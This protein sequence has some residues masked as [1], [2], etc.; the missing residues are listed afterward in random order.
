MIFFAESLRRGED[1]LVKMGPS[2]D[3]LKITPFDD[4]LYL[5]TAR[6]LMK[7]ERLAALKAAYP[8]PVP[9]IR[10]SYV[11]LPE[12]LQTPAI[13]RW[14]KED[15]FLSQHLMDQW[16]FENIQKALTQTRETDPPV[17]DEISQ[18][19]WKLSREGEV[20]TWIVF[21][22]RVFLDIQEILG[23]DI[24][25]G[26]KETCA[27]GK[28]VTNTLGFKTLADGRSAPFQGIG[29][30]WRTSDAV[31][32][33]R[34]GDLAKIWIT[35]NPLPKMRD[36]WMVKMGGQVSDTFQSM[37]TLDPETRKYVN[38]QLRAKY[39][40]FT[41]DPGPEVASQIKAYGPLKPIQPNKDSNFMHTHNPLLCGTLAFQ[42]ALNREQAGI[43]LAN[44]HVSIFVVA[45]LYNALR[46]LEV[47]EERW[48]DIEQIIDLHI[49][50]LFAGQLPTT[51]KD[52]HSRFSLQLGVSAQSFAR[53][54]RP[55]QTR[56][57]RG[58]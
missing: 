41:E 52:L 16:F 47:L 32:V 9:P 10:M 31:Q 17:M 26:Y 40:N 11:A 2:V 58:F 28:N 37:D 57:P 56:R 18:G 48:P 45:H 55:G 39:P 3:S 54:Q 20:S 6:I 42:L 13:Q 12:L 4:F 7:F 30:R 14:D 38:D 24:V 29:E 36:M 21:A 8:Q 25:R 51:P 5:P 35:D 15:E 23:D 53:N 1:P 43:S 19:F 46:Q 33:S 50:T 22:S 27:A 34:L 49:K 44:H